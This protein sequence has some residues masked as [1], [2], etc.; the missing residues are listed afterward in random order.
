MLVGHGIHHGLNAIIGGLQ[1]AGDA[2]AHAPVTTGVHARRMMKMGAPKFSWHIGRGQYFCVSPPMHQGLGCRIVDV[3]AILHLKFV[4]HL[5]KAIRWVLIDR[6]ARP[7]R[8]GLY[9][10]S[11]PCYTIRFAG[12][13][14][15]LMNHAGFRHVHG[16]GVIPQW[17]AQF[18]QCRHNGRIL[19]G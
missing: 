4:Q 2:V 15:Y 9:G 10:I 8:M 5:I 12:I 19:C 11:K 18:N 3:H 16:H 13:Q 14:P 1:C 6:R 17:G 7:F